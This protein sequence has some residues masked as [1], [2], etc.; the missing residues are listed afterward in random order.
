MEPK[1]V[2][3]RKTQSTELRARRMANQRITEQKVKRKNAYVV[4]YCTHN[5]QLIHMCFVV[6]FFFLSVS[7]LIYD[8][9]EQRLIFPLFL[10]LGYIENLI[11]ITYND[12][13][14]HWHAVI[15]Q[16]KKKKTQAPN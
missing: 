14:H 9:L 10:S 11:F 2:S 4:Q 13:S 1:V 16:K 12:R 6:V 15:H 3:E 8:S 7:I 5:E